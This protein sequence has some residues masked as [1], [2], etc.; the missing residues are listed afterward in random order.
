VKRKINIFLL[1][2][3]FV[4]W[5]KAQD[6]KKGITLFTD[7]DL[8]ISGETLLLKVFVPSIEKSGTVSVDLIN[9]LGKKILGIIK[10]VK[11]QQADGFI[12]LPDSLSSGCYLLKSSTL[13]SNVVTIK[14]LYISN[15]FNGLPLTNTTI[16]PIGIVPSDE[17]ANPEIQVNG[18]ENQ[19]K[20]R[21]KVKADL[22]LTN[23][24]LGQIDGDLMVKIAEVIPEFKTST[25]LMK[26]NGEQNRIA[27]HKGILLEGTVSELRSSKPY[28]NAVVFLTIPDSLPGFQYF[29]TGEDGRFYFQ[30]ENYY[31]SIPVVIQ[32]HAKENA[33]LKIHLN[34]Q[35]SLKWVLPHFEPQ[36]FP[37]GLRKRVERNTDAI[38]FRKIF[39]QKEV[40][41]QPSPVIKRDTYPF[42]GNPTKTVDPQLFVDLPDFSDISRELLPGVKFRT[43]NRV[44]SLQVLNMPM[45]NYFE[46]P[47]LV[48]F[49]GIPTEDL[50]M[51]KSLG[52]ADIDKIEIIN[53]ERFFGDLSFQG[54]VAIY[55]S[56]ADYSKIPESDNLIKLNLDVIQP[57]AILNFTDAKSESDPDF[58]QALLWKPSVKPEQTIPIEFQASDIQGT[59]KLSI[60]GKTKDGSVF[61][62]ELTFEVN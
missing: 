40:T 26:T 45:F 43:Y 53:S 33:L 52:S 20:P 30:I 60:C 8:Y 21:D 46:D 59:Y 35:D 62:K 37:S 15:R 55:S 9:H 54:V 28:K 51:I 17:I 3:L 44:P 49:D 1:F 11:N 27:N 50:N 13:L 14:E 18:I 6:G 56:K 10:E 41:E 4:V 5:A 32:C 38:T 61:N 31:G 48:L 16:H 24:F 57:Q 12:V 36:P 34:D 19:Y 29:I 47:P 42:Y 39:H 25:F 2:L 22:Q 7:R 23:N 58:R